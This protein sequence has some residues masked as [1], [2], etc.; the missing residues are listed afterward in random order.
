MADVVLIEHGYCIIYR[1][2]L[3]PKSIMIINTHNL[4]A[5]LAPLTGIH[6]QLQFHHDQQGGSSAADHIPIG[7]RTNPSSKKNFIAGTL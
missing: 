1:A 7:N 5:T 4:P 2:D 6:R 3:H